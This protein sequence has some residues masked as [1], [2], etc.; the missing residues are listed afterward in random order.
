MLTNYRLILLSFVALLCGL[1]AFAQSGP[2]STSGSRVTSSAVS[3]NAWRGLTPLRSTVTD[4]AQMF[5]E[6]Q[7]SPDASLI[8]PY[9]VEDGEVSFTYLTPS[10]A[11]LYRAPASMTN[12]LFTIYFKPAAPL[13][14]ADVQLDRSFKRCA[15]DGIKGRYYLI[16]DAGVA[17][18]IAEDSE[19]VET[20]IYQ[21]SRPE[22]RRLAVSTEC[23]F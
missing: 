5:G 21:P 4:I 1:C 11:K 15:E 17:Y 10:L 8:G 23:V 6:P 18:Q 16:S 12:K 2:R 19:R 22:V 13:F 14:R 7:S 9:R 20:I 3:R